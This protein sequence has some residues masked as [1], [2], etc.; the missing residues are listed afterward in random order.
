MHN[1]NIVVPHRRFETPSDKVNQ[2]ESVNWARFR[3]V[4]LYRRAAELSSDFA[5]SFIYDLI[6]IADLT[7]GFIYIS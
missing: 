6:K 4:A 7:E 2:R 1:S 3:L 5:A